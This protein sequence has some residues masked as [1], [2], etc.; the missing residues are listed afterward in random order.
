MKK[1]CAG[2]TI[3]NEQ[4]GRVADEFWLCPAPV[5]VNQTHNNM[6]GCKLDAGMQQDGF[7]KALSTTS[8]SRAALLENTIAQGGG[9]P[10]GLTIVPSL[11]V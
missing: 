7:K 1:L 5:F 10:A 6:W 8:S 9:K 11:V 4:A 2:P 3:A